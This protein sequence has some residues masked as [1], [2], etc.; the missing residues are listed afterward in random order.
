MEDLL[1]Q[2]SLYDEIFNDGLD[3]ES[4]PAAIWEQDAA[5]VRWMSCSV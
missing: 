4:T 3:P 2:P 5:S 1:S